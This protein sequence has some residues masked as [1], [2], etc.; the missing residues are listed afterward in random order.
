MA[1]SGTPS[2][3]TAAH[4]AAHVVQQ[5][6]GVQL[7]G[8]VGQVGDRYE[9]NADAVADLVVR[10]ESA[11]ALL[12]EVAGS[13]GGGTGVQRA[14]GFEFQ[15]GWGIARSVLVSHDEG[16][17]ETKERPDPERQ[18]DWA[19]ERVVHPGQHER[20]KG[21]APTPRVVDG[22][23]YV[24]VTNHPSLPQKLKWRA[25][26]SGTAYDPTNGSDHR[27]A[28]PTVGRKHLKYHKGQVIKT[29]D[30]FKMTADDA[31]TPL[32]ADLEWVI[33]PPLQEADGED[34]VLGVVHGLV[35]TC[36]KLLGFKHRESFLLSEVT[37]STDDSSVELHPG[38]KG[39]GLQNMEAM[40]QATGGVRIER[41]MDLF[42]DLGEKRHRYAGNANNVLAG[43]AKSNLG[44]SGLASAGTMFSVGQRVKRNKG[45]EGEQEASPQ[46]Q[47]LVAFLSRYIEMSRGNKQH[48]YAKHPTLFL[49]RTDIARMFKM[50]PHIERKTYETFPDQFVR[51]V[52][53][54]MGTDDAPERKIFNGGIKGVEDTD[55]TLTIG[56]WLEGLTE[57]QD[58]LTAKAWDLKQNVGTQEDPKHILALES[59][60]SL[61]DKTDK[62]DGDQNEQRSGLVMEFRGN[63][64]SPMKIG[65]WADFVI[66]TFR[67]LKA[68]NR[69]EMH[70]EEQHQPQNPPVQNQVPENK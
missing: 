14:V 30:G 4:E 12:D 20:Q 59:M 33:D 49:A 19:D 69:G 60:G 25:Q 10:G 62:L 29:F 9:A 17:Q 39:E 5:A 24:P 67:Y 61:G 42:K 66:S 47:G 56:Q 46:L 64:T 58:R 21:W 27:I 43:K 41:L 26:Q 31:S 55:N 63:N 51:D 1:F 36:M 8:G 50:L 18:E 3:H 2:L 6:R 53:G 22:K 28:Y 38:A 34:K 44:G 54:A 23:K 45:Q 57:G 37:G 65:K 48:I 15:T 11:E 40:V 52:L 16:V 7:D 68:L 70:E 35:K 32:G 13:G